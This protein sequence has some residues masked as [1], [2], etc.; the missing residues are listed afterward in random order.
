MPALIMDAVPV[1]LSAAANGLNSLMRAVG[2]A[3]SSS[4]TDVVLA[5]LTAGVGSAVLPSAAGIQ[6]ALLISAGA[7]IVGLGVTLLIPRRVAA[8]SVPDAALTPAAP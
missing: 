1:G 2:T 8:A 7:S 6:V 4:V 3:L 5:G